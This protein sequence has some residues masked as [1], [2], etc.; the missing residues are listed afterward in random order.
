[1]ASF[2]GLNAD[3]SVRVES[4]AELVAQCTSRNNMATPGCFA[5]LVFHPAAASA[6]GQPLALV[7]YTILYPRA[8]LNDGI[9][10]NTLGTLGIAG[11][12]SLQANVEL[13]AIAQASPAASS[14]IFKSQTSARPFTALSR[15]ELNSGALGFLYD[16]LSNTGSAV[17]ALMPVPSVYWLAHTVASD[18]ETGVRDALCIMGLSTRTYILTLALRYACA[19]APMLLILVGALAGGIFPAAGFSSC[20]LLALL[21]AAALF[22]ATIAF[23]SRWRTA[24]LAGA[25]AAFA[26]FV[27][28]AVAGQLSRVGPNGALRL[29][30]MLALPGAFLGFGFAFLAR[31][32]QVDAVLSPATW[33]QEL[34]SQ[35][36]SFLSLALAACGSVVL[37]SLLAWAASASPSCKRTSRA[38]DGVVPS[39]PAAH[40]AASAGF[41]TAS[42]DHDAASSRSPASES[43]PLLQLRGVGKT[44]AGATAASVRSVTLS[45]H[46]SEV[47]VLLGEN[48]CGKTTT[49]GMITGR[50]APTSGS[51]EHADG[52][53]IGWCPQHD[54]LWPDVTVRETLEVYAA[55]KGVPAARISEEAVA[56]ATRAGLAAQQTVLAETLS[57][58]QK[59]RL[60]LA[61][62]LIG[63]SQIL[64]LDEPTAGVD[65][66]NRRLLW[67]LIVAHKAGRTVLLTT[68][69]LDEAEALS[70]RVA[71][72]HEGSIRAVGTTLQLKRSL[73]FGYNMT[74]TCSHREGRDWDAHSLAILT[75]A[76]VHV[77]AAQI[78]STG[79]THCELVIG[80]PLDANPAVPGLL[81]ALEANS[82]RLEI[83]AVAVSSASLHDVFSRLVAHPDELGASSAALH[84]PST[85]A[86]TAAEADASSPRS[87]IDVAATG[88]ASAGT[89]TSADGVSSGSA[90]ARGAPFAPP[91][92]AAPSAASSNS[93]ALR[94]KPLS[95]AALPPLH[96]LTGV[97]A[98]LLSLRALLCKRA[99]LARKDVKASLVPL[100][101]MAAVAVFVAAAFRAEPAVACPSSLTAQ[102][103]VQ[104]VTSELVTSARPFGPS[105]AL[106]VVSGSVLPAMLPPSSTV[107]LNSSDALMVAMQTSP[108]GIWGAIDA[109]WP[110]AAAWPT[111]A[112]V[113]YDIS[114]P[115]A[116]AASLNTLHNALADHAGLGAQRLVV[117]L[118]ALPYRISAF[119]SRDWDPFIAMVAALLI[120]CAFAVPLASTMVVAR[121]RVAGMKLQQRLSGVSALQ[122]WLAH[123]AWDCVPV[124]L[125][126]AIAA[127]GLAFTPAWIPGFGATFVAFIIYGLA[128]AAWGYALSFSAESPAGAVALH[129][130]VSFLLAVG[131]VAAVVVADPAS[132]RQLSTL[133][134]Y[135][136]LAAHPLSA[137]IVGVVLPGF[138]MVL[139]LCGS[140]AMRQLAASSAPS[141]V[142]AWLAWGAAGRAVAVIA[143]HA[144]LA[145]SIVLLVEQGRFQSCSQRERTRRCCGMCGTRSLPLDDVVAITEEDADVCAERSRVEAAYGSGQ[146]VEHGFDDEVVVRDVRK[147]FWVRKAQVAAVDGV[148]IGL[149]PR[150]CYGHLGQNGAGKTT[151]LRIIAGEEAPTSGSVRVHGHD[152]ASDLQG[153]QRS[154]GVC[155]QFNRLYDELRA[156]DHLR[157]FAAIKGLPPGDATETELRRLLSALDLTEHARK[158]SGS[159]SGG[160]KRKLSVAIA[161]VG[162]PPV[163]ILDE[164]S[165]Y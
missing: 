119:S 124:V 34:R 106:A 24:R 59:R 120:A 163:I 13:G 161:L 31:S 77:P 152:L 78:V 81:R 140:E 90:A 6:A 63:G 139:S 97:P 96:L 121:E 15:A 99:L 28:I 146:A 47:L 118:Q 114:L 137:L 155:P 49:M 45:C 125:L 145:F 111:Q 67:D 16:F 27:V 143:V 52:A 108:G 36:T 72:M 150:S 149:S 48:G 38:P 23:T 44:Y 151:L 113:A 58:G 37:Y 60:S 87:A 89:C 94:G 26:A 40:D 107:N 122:Y 142:A 148:T 70:D 135:V 157:L 86:L 116:D 8:G 79:S 138:N 2:P 41:D 134:S 33:T 123:A 88:G 128:S 132:G 50:V 75:H 162:R 141:G 5:G 158:P 130:G 117:S 74:V 129:G 93:A 144:A 21:P 95:E 14:S 76:Q 4:I 12:L 68:H 71:L 32:E 56:W 46:E 20:V 57:G 54:I 42:I 147:T 3:N 9:S 30:S 85:F 22:P 51:V 136:A 29:A 1:M 17:V 62:A 19:C 92:A 10:V 61:A 102:P 55:V 109:A 83:D 100:V 153:L 112:S 127:A 156:V 103:A 39:V 105:R 11:I 104:S 160:N 73:G 35:G 165:Y 18:R 133:M 84:A 7:N 159:L 126:A 115:M 101:F 131:C 110:A 91:A 65:P 164:V 98:W 82:A 66:A 53:S 64:L 80:L 25:A 154:V 43:R 69:F